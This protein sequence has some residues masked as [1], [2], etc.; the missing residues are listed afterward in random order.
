MTKALLIIMSIF[1]FHFCYAQKEGKMTGTVTDSLQKPLQYATVGLYK[2]GNTTTPVRTTY[3]DNKGIFNIEKVDTGNYTL[4]LS[5]SG[6]AAQQQQVNVAPGNNDVAFTLGKSSVNLKEVAITVIKPLVEQTD[7]K[8]VYNAANDPA[9][10]TE[11]AIDILKKTPFVSVDGDN[12]VQVNGQSNFKVLLNGRE[13]AMFTQNVKDALKSFPGA[14]ITKIEVIT[15][16]S[17]KYD[18][19]GVGGIINIITQKKV[20]GY[21]GSIS[22]YYSTQNTLNESAELSVKAG[23]L[24]V[25]GYYSLYTGKNQKGTSMVETT[26]LVP[27]VFTKRSILGNRTSSNLWNFGNIEV[28]YELDSMNTVSTYGNI[29]GGHFKSLNDQTVD[30]D[31]PSSPSTEGKL[32]LQ[33]KY[34]YPTTGVGMDYI[35]KFRSNKEKEFSIRFNGQF[36][37][38]SGF[39]ETAEREPTY[40][41]YVR[42]NSEALNKEYTIQSD[43]VLPLK[44]NQKLET[45]VKL[46][47]RNASS[48]YAN[49]IKYDE[50]A[51]YS[52]NP[53]NTDVFSYRQQV[54]SGYG[55]YNFKV[56]KF[57]VRLGLRF[58]A[59]DIHA[60]FSSSS[61]LVKQQYSNLIPN[62]QIT[63]K[64][65]SSYTAVLSYNMRIQRPYITSLN[66]FVN[67][68]DSLNVFFGNPNLGPQQIHTISLQNRINKGQTFAGVTFTGSY[69]DN[70]IVQYASFNKAT[71]ITSTTS[72]NVGKEIQLSMAVNLNTKLMKDWTI[73]LNGTARYNDVSSTLASSIGKHGFS[74]NLF[75]NSSY[76]VTKKFTISG[77]GG[78]YRSPYTLLSTGGLNGWYQVNFGHKFLKEKLSATINFNNFLKKNSEYHNTNSDNNFVT[79]YVYSNPYRVVFVGVTWNF[80]KL[81]ESVS[82]KKGVNNDDLVGEK[83]GGN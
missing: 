11:T 4:I 13:T 32:L 34:D 29:S 12:N 59:T 42:N 79:K 73:S 46:I 33:S 82:K 41:R 30:I 63:R 39:N 51:K 18:A 78:F 26:P 3:T 54:Y 27:T 76:K 74:G 36:S 49:L 15:N 83:Q 45:G 77:S 8:V 72:G 31:Y 21:N 16:P 60:D 6:Y 62:I 50:N 81:T 17:A 70:M 14:L 47:L 7:D 61:T 35:R 19:E 71:G 53:G 52:A 58:E 64:L 28:S 22:S 2:T 43:Y 25:T 65:T 55:S 69:S 38:N 67:N 44:H 40:Q 10:K 56:K 20:V 68:N 80:G 23:K 66:P 5:H 57:G 1:V 37:E 9:A 75:A 24:G 48:D